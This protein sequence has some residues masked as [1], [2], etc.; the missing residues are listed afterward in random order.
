MHETVEDAVSHGRIADLLMPTGH[1]HL[2][3][4]DHA[5][6]LVT[7]LADFLEV[8]TFRFGEHRDRTRAYGRFDE[9]TSDRQLTDRRAR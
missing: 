7:L 6:G 8:S 4:Q 9:G 5:S 3:G 1:W 2:R